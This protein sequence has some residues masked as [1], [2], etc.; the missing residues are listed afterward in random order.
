MTLKV[1]VVKISLWA[2]FLFKY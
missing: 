2:K 1:K